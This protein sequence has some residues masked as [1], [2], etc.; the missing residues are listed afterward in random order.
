VSRRSLLTLVLAGLL[1]P[2]S[3]LAADE[4]MPSP[5][6]QAVASTGADA[7]AMAS[8]QPVLAQPEVSD[9]VPGLDQPLPEP[10]FLVGDWELQAVPWNKLRLNGARAHAIPT[11]GPQ[12]ADGVPMRPLGPGGRL[13]Y[14]PTVIAQQGMKRL[15]GYVQSGN[16]VHLRYARKYARVLDDLAT[17]GRLRR[18]Q[19]HDYDFGVH[20]SG[21]V[22]S[23]SHGLVLSFLSRFHALT[24]SPARLEAATRMVAAL[25]Q[26]PQNERWISLVTGGGYLWFEHWPDG[27]H[28]HTLNAH[29]NALFGLYDYWVSTGSPLAEQ[30]FLGGAQTVRDKLYRFRRKGDLSRYSLS[31]PRG[32]LHYHMT[33]IDQLRTLALM[34]GDGWFA[35]QA[36]L[37]ERDE[38]KWRAENR[39]GGG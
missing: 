39:G 29:I 5:V 35:R 9:P 31:V 30:Y 33:H 36:R 22:N 1:L 10:D 26:R 15:D 28:D 38:R 12:D 23:N 13:V 20:G 37:F 4:P 3:A 24:D 18:W 7:S 14:N 16:R 2:G 27:L 17:G 34:T 6:P 21:W 8:L 11:V 25:E 32:S 19:P